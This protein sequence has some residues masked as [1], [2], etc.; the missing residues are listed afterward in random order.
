MLWPI[1]YQFET[2]FG[3][4]ITD[5]SSLFGGRAELVLNARAHFNYGMKYDLK[6]CLWKYVNNDLC[7]SLRTS[8]WHYFRT[9][10]FGTYNFC[11]E[12]FGL[13]IDTGLK[14]ELT[15]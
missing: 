3:G 7:V 2:N 8:Q 9:S 6:T 15:L 4:K 12:F 14:R 5:P 11:G 10:F 1:F 13:V